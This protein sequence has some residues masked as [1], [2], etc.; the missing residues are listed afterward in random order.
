MFPKS[1]FCRV[2]RFLIENLGVFTRAE[3]CFVLILFRRAPDNT[4][5]DLLWS[6][7]T[8][9]NPKMKWQAI[10]RLRNRGCLSVTGRGNW[11]KYVLDLDTSKPSVPANGAG[12]SLSASP[13][14][15]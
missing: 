2:P 9:L 10:M 4:V 6:E 3:L 8:G 12:G 13:E 1:S 14:V 15:K 11:A 7:M 5:S